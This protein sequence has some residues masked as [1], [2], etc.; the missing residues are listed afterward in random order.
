MTAVEYLQNQPDLP[1]RPGG[2]LCRMDEKQRKEAIKLI[3]LTCSYYDNGDCL[4]LGGAEAPVSCPQCLTASICCRF[5]RY[6]LL[7][8]PERSRLRAEIFPEKAAELRKCAVCGEEFV[9]KS[10]RA[11]YCQACKGVVRNAQAK[12]RMRNQRR[13][14]C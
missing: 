2:G 14:A 7:A 9:A 11:K 10:N 8:A 3:K 6:V 5:F 4:Y 12:E 1:R 13:K